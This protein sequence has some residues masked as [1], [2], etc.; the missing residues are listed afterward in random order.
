MAGYGVGGWP[1]KF[2][3]V[4]TPKLDCSCAELHLAPPQFADGNCRRP[5]EY[6]VAED[7]P[8]CYVEATRAGIRLK[9]VSCLD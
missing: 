4:W 9:T 2:G 6:G 3:G 8:L 1:L 5:S 7:D